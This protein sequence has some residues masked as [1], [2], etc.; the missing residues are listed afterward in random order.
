MKICCLYKQSLKVLW[1]KTVRKQAF[2]AK[3]SKIAVNVYFSMNIIN[4]CWKIRQLCVNFQGTFFRELLGWIVLLTILFTEKIEFWQN[5][6]KTWLKESLMI[7]DDIIFFIQLVVFA[8]PLPWLG[9]RKHTICWTKTIYH[10]KSWKILYLQN[11][12]PSEP[13]SC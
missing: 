7:C 11:T 5:T 6:R 8:I 13:I 4:R 2:H 1:I 9:D 12:W 10:R 3:N